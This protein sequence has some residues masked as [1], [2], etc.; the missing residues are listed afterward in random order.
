MKI[1]TATC[2]L[3]WDLLDGFYHICSIKWIWELT[4][5]YE[6]LDHRFVTKLS[7]LDSQMARMG[8]NMVW[9]GD[10]EVYHEVNRFSITFWGRSGGNS[11]SWWGTTRPPASPPGPIQFWSQ[12]QP[13]SF[14]VHHR[15]P[16]HPQS[17]EVMRSFGPEMQSNTFSS[18]HSVLSS[19][20]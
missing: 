9:R 12:A 5:R 14:T 15:E 16:K 13:R 8:V 17:S 2:W 19:L 3:W 7:R 11:I 4:R 18:P 1:L 6:R 20:N 10:F